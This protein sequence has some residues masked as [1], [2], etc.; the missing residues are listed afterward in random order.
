M[1]EGI[2]TAVFDYALGEIADDVWSV[3]R[4]GGPDRLTVAGKL[5]L[6]QVLCPGGAEH[7]GIL[8][9]ENSVPKEYASHKH[10]FHSPIIFVPRLNEEEMI[11]VADSICSRLKYTK[12]KAYFLFPLKGVGDYSKSGGPL[13][14]KEADKAFLDR[15]KQCL[16]KNIEVLERNAF[17]EDEIFVKEAADLLI[18]LIKEKHP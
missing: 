2:I 14:D 10:V 11:M 4:A 16:P 7:L 8:V 12:D 17:I 3:L 9:P 5:G 13:E 15:L 1:K 18:S 6:P